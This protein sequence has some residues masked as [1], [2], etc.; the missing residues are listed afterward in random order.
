MSLRWDQPLC[1]TSQHSV[2]GWDTGA[3][4]TGFVASRT[5]AGGGRAGTT[6]TAV[7]AQRI[8]HLGERGLGNTQNSLALNIAASPHPVNERTVVVL[9]CA[10]T[11]RL[12]A[13]KGCTSPHQPRNFCTLHMTSKSSLRSLGCVW[14]LDI[15]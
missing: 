6:S 15:I 12:T 14:L 13:G 1:H 2:R 11:V 8:Q 10:P 3:A 9:C 4:W 5:W 7:T